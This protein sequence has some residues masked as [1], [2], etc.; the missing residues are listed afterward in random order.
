M[1]HVEVQIIA[2]R[3]LISERATLLGGDSVLGLKHHLDVGVKHSL[4]LDSDLGDAASHHVQHVDTHIHDDA[5]QAEVRFQGVREQVLQDGVEQGVQEL[6]IVAASSDEEHIIRQEANHL[7]VQISAHHSFPEKLQGLVAAHRAGEQ[8]A[9]DTL[10]QIHVGDHHGR[11]DRPQ[12]RLSYSLAPLPKRT[13]RAKLLVVHLGGL[14]H[15]LA[16]LAHRQ[17]LRISASVV[18]RNAHQ[19]V[20]QT[21]RQRQRAFVVDRLHALRLRGLRTHSRSDDAQGTNCR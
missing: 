12:E 3:H 20:E 1:I 11:E 19:E 17:R 4:L 13:P 6:V 14:L 21:V 2:R 9:V 15:F 16:E 10:A 8:E 7:L 5:L 18:A